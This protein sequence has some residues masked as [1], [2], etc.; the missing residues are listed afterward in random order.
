MPENVTVGPP[1]VTRDT[2]SRPPVWLECCGCGFRR[3]YSMRHEH[4]WPVTL[5][6][7]S[8]AN[9]PKSSARALPSLCA[10]T[11]AVLGCGSWRISTV[12]AVGVAPVYSRHPRAYKN[13]VR[14]TLP[15]CYVDIVRFNNSLA[16]PEPHRPHRSCPAHRS[17]G[18]LCSWWKQSRRPHR[19]RRLLRC[20]VFVVEALPPL[21]VR[22]GALFSAISPMLPRR[23]RIAGALF[24][25]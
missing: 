13:G 5:S 10:G 6:A 2:C 4:T 14:A 23:R 1:D 12:P 22:R 11:H 21:R 16:D 8:Q 9:G 3:L 18:A 17:T 19:P 7:V 24:L 15:M 25:W 20:T